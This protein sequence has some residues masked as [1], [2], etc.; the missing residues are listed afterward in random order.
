MP[1]FVH[2]NSMPNKIPDDYV[3]MQKC[4]ICGKNSGVILMSKRLKSIPEEQAYSGICDKCKPQ[5][6]GKVQFICD[7]CRRHGWIDKE[8]LKKI[9]KPE[10]FKDIKPDQGIRFEKCPQCAGLV[11]SNDRKKE[12]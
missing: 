10:F 12:R 5:L 6:K 7:T 1:G 9:I 8:K 4:V 11:K 3:R 2:M